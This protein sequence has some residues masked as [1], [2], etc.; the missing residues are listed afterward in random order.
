M[1]LTLLTIGLSIAQWTF[2]A[3]GVKLS[4]TAT[5]AILPSPSYIT[6]PRES[7]QQM[8]WVRLLNHSHSTGNVRE[9]TFT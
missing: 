2:A 6:M 1:M 4:N 8:A 3:T 7:S 5:A 9:N